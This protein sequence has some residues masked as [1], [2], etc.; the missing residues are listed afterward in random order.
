[1]RP[2]QIMRA[3]VEDLPP[4]RSV[5]DFAEWC[6]LLDRSST[7]RFRTNNAWT[8][9]TLD[10]FWYVL[11]ARPATPTPR[12]NPMT[13]HR[14]TYR[15]SN[16]ITSQFVVPPATIPQIRGGKPLGVNV[17]SYGDFGHDADL[18]VA[19]WSAPG[20][21][22]RLSVDAAERLIEELEDA[23]DLL[24]GEEE[25]IAEHVARE[26]K[27]EA[28]AFA[29]AERAKKLAGPPAVGAERDPVRSNCWIW[30]DETSFQYIYDY[31]RSA[32]LPPSSFQ[33]SRSYIH[34]NDIGVVTPARLALWRRVLGN[35]PIPYYLVGH[36]PRVGYAS[37]RLIPDA[38]PSGLKVW[39]E[40]DGTFRYSYFGQGGGTKFVP[41]KTF[42]GH[43]DF[44]PT[45][46]NVALWTE[47]AR[48]AG[49]AFQMQATTS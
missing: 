2:P 5:T 10:C 31:N 36:Y 21:T 45:A 38:Y 15:I 49:I 39:C 34:G 47:M 16:N 35:R 42:I 11:P 37:A 3:A 40:A 19:V 23:V 20:Q 14:K 43:K 27:K 26:E 8:I 30:H 4:M 46:A 33:P 48:D 1:M 9:E 41:G 7:D 18:H 44:A 13:D 22:L 32:G 29:A 12:D 17:D 28:E 25:L 6:R 24:R